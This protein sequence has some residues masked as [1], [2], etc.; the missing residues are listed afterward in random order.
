[1]HKTNGHLSYCLCK[2]DLKC[3]SRI[4]GDSIRKKKCSRKTGD[5]KCRILPSPYVQPK[6]CMFT[7]TIAEQTFI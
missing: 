1:M 6:E 4:T 2:V 5:V 7:G 3:D